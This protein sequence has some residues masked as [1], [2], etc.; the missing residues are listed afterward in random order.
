MLK[1]DSIYHIF[2]FPR[3]FS[4]SSDQHPD[5][6]QIFLIGS[7]TWCTS[8]AS[9]PGSRYPYAFGKLFSLD[10]T[11]K[12]N[13]S[14]DLT[15]TLAEDLKRQF[16]DHHALLLPITDHSS[17]IVQRQQA[18][19]GVHRIWVS[20]GNCPI[21]LLHINDPSV[22]DN[23]VFFSSFDTLMLILIPRDDVT[24]ETAPNGSPISERNAST[25]LVTCIPPERCLTP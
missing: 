15:A 24:F 5:L 1:M 11:V 13:A 17:V 18:P 19:D 14:P 22:V 10:P 9:A 23:V 7:R 3:H 8:N 21:L 16:H 12:L 2:C 6:A 20:D 25:Y 4:F